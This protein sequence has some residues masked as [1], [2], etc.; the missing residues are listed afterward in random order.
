MVFEINVE[1]RFRRT[2]YVIADNE[3]E[4]N[5]ILDQYFCGNT[6]ETCG[7]DEDFVPYCEEDIHLED[8]E[9]TEWDFYDTESI[10]VSE[11]EFNLL[12]DKYCEENNLDREEGWRKV[13]VEE[14]VK[15]RGDNYFN[16]LEELKQNNIEISNF[17]WQDIIKLAKTR[18]IVENLEDLFDAFQD[19]EMF[20]K[21]SELS[22][23]E[24]LL[25]NMT[26]M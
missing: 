21:K 1:E 24:I 14:F 3:R 6:L 2:Y 26:I 18:L 10:N 25:F 19:L 8:E 17:E 13:P 22:E 23:K 20:R 5:T 16:L 12:L 11:E 4:A 9:L 15:W 7:D